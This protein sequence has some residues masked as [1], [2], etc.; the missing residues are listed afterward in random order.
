MAN[1]QNYQESPDTFFQQTK[2]SPQ[3]LSEA[4]CISVLVSDGSFELLKIVYSNQ[5]VLIKKTM[6]HELFDLE[7]FKNQVA[8]H[9]RLDKLEGVGKILE[10]GVYREADLKEYAY[11]VYVYHGEQIAEKIKAKTQYSPEDCRRFVVS[12][13]KTLESLQRLQIVHL[14]LCPTNVTFSATEGKTCIESLES[15][16]SLAHFI[17]CVGVCEYLPLPFGPVAFLAPEVIAFI[18]NKEGK[19]AKFNP[20]SASVYSVGLIVVQM[21]TFMADIQILG[22]Q[23]KDMPNLLAKAFESEPEGPAKLF[24]GF[25]R[26]VLLDPT[27]EGRIDYISLNALLEFVNANKSEALCDAMALERTKTQSTS[28]ISNF[29]REDG[30]LLEEGVAHGQSPRVAQATQEGPAEPGRTGC[31][32]TGPTVPPRDKYRRTAAHHHLLRQRC[33]QDQEGRT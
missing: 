9:N 16:V 33:P 10:F 18:N 22:T 30:L 19:D 1:Y 14:G 32:E 24:L 31:A 13:A 11:L 21:L 29:R 6:M 27:N 23:P 8:L 3:K 4:P 25:V 26:K 28:S 2:R 15:A 17:S 12:L 7:S 5:H 20:Y